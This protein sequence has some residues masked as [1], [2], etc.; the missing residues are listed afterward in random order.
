M[1]GP[2]LTEYMDAMRADYTERGV[3]L[4][5]PEAQRYAGEVA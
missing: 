5:D 4:T 3:R 1:T 2:E